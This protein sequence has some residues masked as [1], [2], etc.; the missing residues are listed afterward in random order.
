MQESE[1]QTS[2]ELKDTS[3]SSDSPLLEL[4]VVLATDWPTT[5][6]KS[7]AIKAAKQIALIYIS[8][9]GILSS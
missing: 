3:S 2:D 4:E 7:L 8:G 5:S 9:L 1:L 6:V